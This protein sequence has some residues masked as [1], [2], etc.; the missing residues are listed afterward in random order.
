MD[1]KFLG[2]IFLEILKFTKN[3]SPPSFFKQSSSNFQETFL[4]IKGKNVTLEF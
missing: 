1:R 3:L 4:I 2:S